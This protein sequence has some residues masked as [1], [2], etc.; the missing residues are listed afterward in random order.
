M[1]ELFS[2]LTPKTY[3]KIINRL[4]MEGMLFTTQDAKYLASNRLSTDKIDIESS[5]S[6]FG[7]LSASKTASLIS[8]PVRC[9]PFLRSPQRIMIMI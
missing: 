8:V 2:H 5:V 1:R 3:G 6:C 9:R 4:H 7:R